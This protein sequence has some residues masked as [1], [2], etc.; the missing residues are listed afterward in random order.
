M[1]QFKKIFEIK[2]EVYVELITAVQLTLSNHDYM[3]MFNEQ[4]N[5]CISCFTASTHV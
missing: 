5:L 3:A 2:I 4:G 1:R